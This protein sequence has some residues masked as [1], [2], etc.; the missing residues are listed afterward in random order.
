MWLF[1][2][3]ILSKPNGGYRYRQ[4]KSL[5]SKNPAFYPHSVLIPALRFTDWTVLTLIVRSNGRTMCSLSGA[6]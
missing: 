1:R 4:F 5:E 6:N 3:I 2:G